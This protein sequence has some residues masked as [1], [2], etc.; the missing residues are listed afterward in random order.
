MAAAIAEGAASA[1]M[2]PS[3]SIALAAW[4][5]LA[6]L[7][8]CGLA[9]VRGGHVQSDEGW[10]L[11]AAREVLQGRLPYRDF[12]YTQGPLH[13]YVYGLAQR[14]LGSG[15]LAARETSWALFL[16][17]VTSAAFVARRFGGALAALLTLAL[18]GS[19]PMTFWVWT[20]PLTHASA[21]CFLVSGISLLTHRSNDVRRE[22]GGLLAIAI[23]A[24]IRVSLVGALACAVVW[25]GWRRRSWA[26][27]AAA[28]S[29]ALALLVLLIGPFA[30]ASTGNFRFG[31]WS[32]HA[33][34]TQQFSPHP[35][36]VPAAIWWQGKTSFLLELVRTYP[37]LVWA[38]LATIL[39]ARGRGAVHRGS[40]AGH[41]HGLLLIA[42]MVIVTVS[43]SMI[44]HPVHVTYAGI[45][46][47]PASALCGVVLAGALSGSR[48]RWM[49]PVAWAVVGCLAIA[50]WAYARDLAP[51]ELA[52]VRQAAVAID[53]AL[54]PGPILTFQNTITAENGRR[55]LPGLEMGP[56]AFWPYMADD[57]AARLGV[58]NTARLCDMVR[59][60][61]AVAVIVTK[62]EGGLSRLSCR[63]EPFASVLA[64]DYVEVPSLRVSSY[65]Q[66]GAPKDGGDVLYVFERRPAR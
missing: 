32:Y 17:T 64:R 36:P 4:I 10:Y 18:I 34:R 2:A 46:V 26:A 15:L 63:G 57:E 27:L 21:G 47:P 30:F 61:E 33:L 59:S 58:V 53:R 52:R 11:T 7:G 50:A 66:Y 3:R 9:F 60:R 43:I 5:A 54:P 24:G 23:G 22:A 40:D 16:A 37:V 20:L 31:V 39:I 65:G 14:V 38:G 49:A 13:P 48:F 62:L 19:A 55:L 35:M 45:L 51:G 25:I 56:F 28:A 42:A 6:I 8:A 41:P 12:M 29:F 44:P 1:P